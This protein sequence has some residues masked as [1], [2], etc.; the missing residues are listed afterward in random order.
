MDPGETNPAL[1]LSDLFV[2]KNTTSPNQLNTS[3][4]G[5]TGLEYSEK[6]LIPTASTTQRH[7]GGYT[8]FTRPGDYRVTT[9]NGITG[10][11][12]GRE[13]HDDEAQNLFFNI[14]MV[15]VTVKVNG[16]EVSE[17]ATIDL[18]QTQQATVTVDIPADE[19]GKNPRQFRTTLLRPEDS[20][21][22]RQANNRV[23]AAQTINGSE[24]V[25][26][27]RFY[28]FDEDKSSYTDESFSRFGIHLG[29]DIHIT[30]KQFVANVIDTLPLRGDS[31]PTSAAA[32]LKQ[33][34]KGFLFIPTAIVDPPELKQ[35]DGRTPNNSDSKITISPIASPSQD[36]KDFIGKQGAAF[37][38]FFA[39]TPAVSASTAIRLEAKVGGTPVT[40]SCNFNLVP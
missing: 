15:D 32:D 27:S 22:L 2:D 39:A 20:P 16:I 4:T 28:D 29:G 6:G 24:R 7:L 19:R 14:T 10:A 26:V 3:V 12:E 33:G 40:L 23:L 5:P 37:E 11:Q 13:A 34:Q 8:A 1:G 25:E 21:V 18:V 38:V 35:F 31:N 17:S 30:V 36:I 9:R